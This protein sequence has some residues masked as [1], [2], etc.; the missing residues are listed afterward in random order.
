M[1]LDAETFTG[2]E[3]MQARLIPPMRR[4]AFKEGREV[5]EEIGYPN[6]DSIMP[7]SDGEPTIHDTAFNETYF[8]A[9]CSA[10]KAWRNGGYEPLQVMMLDRMRPARF[11]VDVKGAGRLDMHLM[12]VRVEG[13]NA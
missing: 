6:I 13:L 10:A 8:G 2:R 3:R 12:P 7:A 11:R 5:D 1:V 4:P 9:V